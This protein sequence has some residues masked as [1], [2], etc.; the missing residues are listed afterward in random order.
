[1]KHKILPCSIIF[2]SMA[3]SEPFAIDRHDLVDA[4]I[5]GVRQQDA[6]LEV[7]VWNGSSVYHE[8]QPTVEWL[9]DSGSVLGTGVVFVLKKQVHCCPHP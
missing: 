9:D 2:L 7:Q 6:L 8:E 3:C 5:L 4:R 1:M